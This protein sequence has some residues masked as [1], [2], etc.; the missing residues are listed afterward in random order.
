M[1][2]ENDILNLIAYSG[3]ARSLAMEAIAYAKDGEFDKAEESLNEADDKLA[4][5]HGIQTSLL[6]REASGENFSMSVLL[7]HAQDHLMNA[8]TIHTMAKEFVDV[9]K[10]LNQLEREKEG[11]R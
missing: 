4:K 5:V 8:I 3:E 11:C 6:Q 7:V 9:F 2:N 10:R 1:D